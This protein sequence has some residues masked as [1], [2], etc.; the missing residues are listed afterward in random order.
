MHKVRPIHP[1]GIR[2]SQ[3]EGNSDTCYHADVTLVKQASH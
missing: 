3:K 1:S 2:L